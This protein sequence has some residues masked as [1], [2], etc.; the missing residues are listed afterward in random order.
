MDLAHMIVA[1]A[2]EQE[3]T[4]HVY[5]VVINIVADTTE[6][7]WCKEYSICKC[8]NYVKIVCDNSFTIKSCNNFEKLCGKV[9]RIILDHALSKAR[10]HFNTNFVY[11]MGFNMYRQDKKIY[12]ET[13]NILNI[14]VY[15]ESF[16]ESLVFMSDPNLIVE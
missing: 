2:K 10:N 8:A 16:I 3:E 9:W 7:K 1:A 15:P 14:G 5:R 13:K 12:S 6:E 11:Q 4:E